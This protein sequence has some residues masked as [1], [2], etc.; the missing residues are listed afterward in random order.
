MTSLARVGG[1]ARFS[2]MP[3]S[4]IR[5]FDYDAQARRLKVTFVTG[6]VYV[7][8]DVPQD[9][10]DA[11]RAAASKGEYFNRAIRDHFRFERL[12]A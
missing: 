4:V 6:R 11:L 1:V 2:P 3:S 10:A 7:Y 12:R 8:L 5:A 9:V